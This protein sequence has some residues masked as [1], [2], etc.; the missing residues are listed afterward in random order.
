MKVFSRVAVAVVAGALIT[1]AH[2]AAAQSRRSDDVRRAP[3][4]ADDRRWDRDDD[5]RG[6]D[7]GRWDR[8]DDR[9]RRNDDWGRGGG[10]YDDNRRRGRISDAE[11][12]RRQ[13][14][15]HIEW[16]RRHRNDRRCAELYRRDGNWC[17][18]RNHD[19]RC[20]YVDYRRRDSRGVLRSDRGPEWERWLR[21]SG[22]D[23]E[24]LLNQ[25][26]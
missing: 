13:R 12:L 11:W 24:A 7:D 6:R 2:D 20:D 25:P 23:V 4:S 19:R 21:S 1:V 15:Q 9:R 26:R 22:V 10:R 8:D 16:C 17:W 5:R 18:D 14:L 3:V